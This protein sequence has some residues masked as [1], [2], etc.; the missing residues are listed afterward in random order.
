MMTKQAAM[1]LAKFDDGYVAR[2][3]HGHWVVWCKDSDHAV[4]FDQR[5]IERAAVLA[6]L[7]R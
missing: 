7:N 6:D 1:Q 5:D 4:E 2:R 3:I